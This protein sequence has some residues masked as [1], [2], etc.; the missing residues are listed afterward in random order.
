MLEAFPADVFNL[1]APKGAKNTLWCHRVGSSTA[2]LYTLFT[3]SS[4]KPT[5]AN[6]ASYT[7][8]T[9]SRHSAALI[10]F[11]LNNQRLWVLLCVC[12]CLVSQ[13][14]QEPLNHSYS[15]MRQWRHAT[16]RPFIKTW[17]Y[18]CWIN[19]INFSNETLFIYKFYIIFQNLEKN[20]FRLCPQY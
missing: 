19:I 3:T 17:L 10:M 13:F 6:T 1:T 18:T 20:F 4:Y 15:F 16:Q 5:Q 12:V 7:I 8:R 11:Y 14:P 9:H 2:N